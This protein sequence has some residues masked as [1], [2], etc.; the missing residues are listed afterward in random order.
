MKLLQKYDRI[1][2][3]FWF[4]EIGEGKTLQAA[5]GVEV[6]DA[7]GKLVMPGKKLSHTIMI[8]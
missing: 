7:S 5:D 1:V 6:V 8:I 4:R 3:I 2:I